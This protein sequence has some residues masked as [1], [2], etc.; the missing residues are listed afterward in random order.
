MKL[1]AGDS[2]TLMFVQISPVDYNVDETLQSL[3]FAARTRSVELG[4]VS[5]IRLLSQFRN[6]KKKYFS[7]S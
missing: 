2:K 3:E 7:Q 4:K 1:L 5:C 6:S